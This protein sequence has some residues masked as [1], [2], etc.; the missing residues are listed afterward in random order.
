MNSE[1]SITKNY[2]SIKLDYEKIVWVAILLFAAVSRFYDLGARVISHDES[3]HTYY[4]WELSQGRGFEHSPLMH[5]P[6]QFHIV[7]FSYFSSVLKSSGSAIRLSFSTF[8]VRSIN[9]YRL[10]GSNFIFPP[11]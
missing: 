9:K 4:A 2:I 8:S 10:H 1:A 11:K 6:F 5:G 7:A 3:L